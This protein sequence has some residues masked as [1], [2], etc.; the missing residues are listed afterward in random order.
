M[1]K[2]P[3][4]KEP[5][6]IAPPKRWLIGIAAVAALASIGIGIYVVTRNPKT[7]TAS[8]ES[9]E[10]VPQIESVSA[11]GR[12]EPAGEVVQLSAP[13]QSFGA[14][15]R[16][17]QLGVKEGSIVKQGQVVAVLDSAARLQTQLRQAEA[18]VRVAQAELTKIRAGA[19]QGDISAQR[20]EVAQQGSRIAQQKANI[21]QQKAN[22]AR[23]EAE[24]ANARAE[25]K[26]H[27]DLHADGA[28]SDSLLDSKRLV[29]Q[30]A[31]AQLYEAQAAL[32]ESQAALKQSE[33]ALRQAGAT[34]ES[35]AEVRPEDVAIARANLQ[36]AQAAYNNAKADFA[37]AV[38]RAPFDG[39]VIQIHTQPGETVGNQGILEL[40]RTEQMYV[41]AEV[42]ESDITKVKPGQPVKVSGQALPS[43][44]RGVVEQIGLEIGK[45]DVLDTD[46][47]ADIDSRV[48]EVKIRLEPEDSKKVA[49]LTNMQVE[50][51]ILLQDVPNPNAPNPNA[52]NQS[53]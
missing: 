17:E 47:A 42:Y 31:A 25:Y 39:Q 14:G 26:R 20:A 41:V 3:D 4:L 10:S 48:V 49:E 13:T 30:T 24:V 18:E 8:S 33:A 36:S 32:G 40:G 37:Q 27:K 45:K 5:P 50:V 23:M 43:N 6:L 12:L 46:P 9:T 44:L 21:A 51:E 34:L 2:Q 52:P 35:V 7:Q 1:V 22:V 16:I 53:S 29:L 28:I 11:L 38:V 15:A 19:K